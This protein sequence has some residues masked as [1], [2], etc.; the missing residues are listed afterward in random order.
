[1]H[2]EHLLLNMYQT[3]LEI[4]GPSHWWPGET[5]FEVAVGAILTQNTNWGNVEKAIRNLRDADCL[6]PDAMLAMPETQLAAL[7]R[8]SGYYNM[9]AKKL[10]TFLVWLQE[11]CDGD[12]TQLATRDADTART[13]LL[14]VKGI[15]PETADSIA[16]YAASLPTFVVDAY[17]Y[18]I[19]TRH[20]LVPEDIDYHG[21]RDFFMDVLPQDVSLFNE[22]HALIVRV[23][24]EWCLKAAPRC[25]T[26][27]LRD[28]LDNGSGA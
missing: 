3:M 10:K 8:P 18:R 17:T 2:R 15:G 13:E 26:C 23:A 28:F 25:A 24:K 1:M 11:T 7:I 16:L 9:K 5:P 12:I 22:Y 27:P 19:L 4:M 14:S 21:M 6:T 20:G